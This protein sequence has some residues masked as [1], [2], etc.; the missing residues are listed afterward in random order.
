MMIK[1]SLYFILLALAVTACF[2]LNKISLYNLSSIYNNTAF[3]EL[4]AVVFN[5]GDNT[6]HIFVPVIRNDMITEQDEESGKGY[7][8]FA[9]K[10]ELFR[11][12]E[13]K[14]ILDSASIIIDDSTLNIAD[15]LIEIVINYPSEGKYIL[16][17]ELTDLNRVDVVRNFYTLDNSGNGSSNNF[18]L[19]GRDNKIQY[20]SVFSS[21]DELLLES[22]ARDIETLFV[23]FYQR[24]FPLALPP[25]LEESN[26][27]FEFNADSVFSMGLEDGRTDHYYLPEEGF[28][29][30]QTDT[31]QR[32]GFTIFRFYDGFPKV[33]SSQHMLAPLRYITTK[34]EYEDIVQ[35]V[36][37]KLAV[38]NFWLET[39][40]NPTRARA[41]IQKYY[42]RVEDAN[43][44]FTSYHEGWKTDRGLL[45]I[46][47]GPPKIV[48]RGKGVEEWL[49]GEKGNSNSIRFEFVKV[50]NPF[51]ENDYSLVKSPSYKEKWYNI[52]NTWRR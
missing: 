3:T 32:S 20:A 45:Y 41:M 9:V 44:F 7:I 13:S 42:S 43:K 31:S 8:K 40:G 21:D 37:L 33:Y 50:E 27:R 28:Y 12:Y 5:S 10:Y 18:L 15:T 35:D 52:V 47:Y 24:D 6:A 17:L 49:Y 48:Y 14:D 4:K 38:D 22:S 36:D 30:F 19:R 51:S 29:H 2:N 26:T 1:K 11:T 16:K 34:K 25:F 23:R 46:V 39:A